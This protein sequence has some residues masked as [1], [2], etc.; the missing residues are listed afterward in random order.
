MKPSCIITVVVMVIPFRCISEHRNDEITHC[1][2][3]KTQKKQESSSFFL[4]IFGFDAQ[5]SYQNFTVRAGQNSGPTY[6]E[7]SSQTVLFKACYSMSS[8]GR[9]SGVLEV[10]PFLVECPTSGV[11]VET[12]DWFAFLVIFRPC[13]YVHVQAFLKISLQR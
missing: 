13:L 10:V 2:D 9:C 12:D 3:C 8:G 6:D 5:V 4:E 11:V 1:L 7:L